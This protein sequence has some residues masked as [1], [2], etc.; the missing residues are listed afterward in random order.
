M[1]GSADRIQRGRRQSGATVI[2]CAFVFPFFFM[3]MYGTAVYGYV[4][5]LN[6]SLNH[7]V[8]QAAASAVTVDPA[9]PDVTTM[10]RARINATVASV[11]GWM[12][13]VQRQQRLQVWVDQASATCPVAQAAGSVKVELVYALR[14]PSW[15]FPVVNMGFGQIPPLP[16]NLNV[17]ATAL[18]QSQT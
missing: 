9:A 16:E 13:P 2:E 14:N 3:L 4:F 10:R 8:Q 5:F 17:C 6:Q 12:N 11:L 7:A 15:L 1:H 18:I